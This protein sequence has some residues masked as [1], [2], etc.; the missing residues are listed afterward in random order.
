[1]KIMDIFPRKKEEKDCRKIQ[2]YSC[3]ESDDWD[4][5]IDYGTTIVRRCYR[6]SCISS[7]YEME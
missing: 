6:I 3:Y 7:D 4:K 5:V 1:M 2:E